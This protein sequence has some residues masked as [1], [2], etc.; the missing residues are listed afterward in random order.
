[1]SMVGAQGEIAF[2]QPRL[3][4]AAAGI[5]CAGAIA[6]SA[7]TGGPLAPA[8]LMLALAIPSALFA[9]Y[10]ATLRRIRDYTVWSEGA[11][12]VRWLSGPW[13]CVGAGVIVAL[14]G[15]LMLGLRLF[16]FEPLDWLLLAFTA[17]VFWGVWR[18][19]RGRL[20][21]E[22]QPVFRIGR[23]L[24]TAA[25][26]T[27]LAMALA[28]VGLRLAIGT[29]ALQP[30]EHA[31]HL[32]GSLLM[33]LLARVGGLWAEM[34]GQAIATLVA[35]GGA[36]EFL[37]LAF[38]ML[39]K[40]VFYLFAALSLAAF[41]V[42]VA[43]YARILAPPLAA[44]R[45]PVVP[46]GRA[47][48]ASVALMIAFGLVYLPAVQVAEMALRANPSI[49]AAPE[50]ARITVEQIGDVLV[51]EGTIRELQR[52]QVDVAAHRETAL[53]G[54]SGA[55]D[56]G[57]D[58]MRGNVDLYL[59]W[60]YSLPSEYVRLAAMLTGSAEELLARRIAEA[61]E[62]GDPFAEATT[63]LSEALAV[64]AALMVSY[65]ETASAIIAENRVE[66][67][68]DVD[69]ETVAHFTIADALHLPTPTAFTTTSQRLG[70]GAASGGIAGI[71]TAIVVRRAV[72]SLSAKGSLRVAA[73]ALQVVG[74][75]TLGGFGGAAAGAAA[76]GTLG[77]VVP[78]FG[79]A[80]G[81]IA[82]GI[83]GGIGVGLGTDYLLLKL[84]ETL[85]RETNRNA[86]LAAIDENEVRARQSL[87]LP[88]RTS[89]EDASPVA[90][91]ALR[92]GIDGR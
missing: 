43:E 75:R 27:A 47:A 88:S 44:E 25:L 80:L 46:T 26:V 59:D 84:E 79:T 72:A 9:T 16:R 86:I 62:T 60:Y 49:L 68:A 19:T 61:L 30:L 54:L 87:G 85:S 82:G 23:P 65:R 63:L 70:I 13:L 34:E 1:M 74:S 40:S 57:F 32:E 55:L 73:K 66:P 51:R 90:G 8:L 67:G 35:Q 15:A 36:G 5:L 33:S 29:V 81:A 77:S 53:A 52:A 4:L 20:R 10:L 3:A 56:A 7:F 28:D 12:A 11:V 83:A 92:G 50:R 48:R 14:A 71:A 37:A 21:R 41:L 39:G 78:G 64:D 6:A 69:V 2:R 76:G 24:W 38:V 91:V 89:L 18:L 42:P 45:P 58:R 17:P 22:F 31:A